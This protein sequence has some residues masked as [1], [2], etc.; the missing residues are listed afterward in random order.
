MIELSVLDPN[1][2]PQ[3]WTTNPDSRTLSSPM[4]YYLGASG[5]CHIKW[6]LLYY[7]QTHTR[8][9]INTCKNINTHILNIHKYRHL[10]VYTYI[11]SKYIG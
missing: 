1:S 10:C 9:Y 6:L 4:P 3:Q 11:W 5:I 7:N 8:I 2:G